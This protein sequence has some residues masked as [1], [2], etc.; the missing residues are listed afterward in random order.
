MTVIH[1]DPSGKYPAVM[2][3]ADTLAAALAGINV[4]RFG[5]GELRLACGEAMAA[6]R[7]DKRLAAELRAILTAPAQNVLPCLNNVFSDTPKRDAWLPWAVPPWT[8]LF[9]RDRVYG[10]V[11]MTRPD[12]APWINTPEY[13]AQLKRLWRG[14]NVVLV[15]GSR[16][17]I[18]SEHLLATGALSVRTVPAPAK[19]AYAEIDRIEAE[20]GGP[21]GNS[22]VILC[23]GMT[24]SCLSNR[25]AKRGVWA[26][27][28]GHVG[29]FMRRAGELP[30]VR[31]DLFS[32]DLQRQALGE[33]GI[34]GWRTRRVDAWAEELNAATILNY[35]EIS[36][37]MPE[38]HDLVVAAGVLEWLELDHLTELLGH[39]RSLARRGGFVSVQTQ[40]VPI[41]KPRTWWQRG[42]EIVGWTVDRHEIDGTGEVRFW[43]RK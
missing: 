18:C 34:T 38:I 14:R 26:A 1:T 30:Y 2:G 4:S 17:S 42:L 13:W 37:G 40:G 8:R 36:K 41:G 21:K 35:A 29:M 11:F 24:A 27:D 3:E 12:S 33:I 6:Q 28:L 19:H 16:R 32:A 39:M 43:L 31:A 15:A 25:L 7:P 10:S 5:D 22:I 9:D 23:L 20:I